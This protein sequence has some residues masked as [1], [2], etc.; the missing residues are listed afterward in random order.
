M[1]TRNGSWVWGF[2]LLDSLFPTKCSDRITTKWKTPFSY[3]HVRQTVLSLSMIWFTRRQYLTPILRNRGRMWAMRT[4]TLYGLKQS[5][6]ERFKLLSSCQES[7]RLV[8]TRITAFPALDRPRKIGGWSRQ[9]RTVRW[10]ARSSVD[11]RSRSVNRFIP[12]WKT[13]SHESFNEIIQSGQASSSPFNAFRKTA[14]EVVIWHMR[15][16]TRENCKTLA[17][18]KRISAEHEKTW[19]QNVSDRGTI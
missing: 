4:S 11:S 17:Y 5:P 10:M 19:L 16:E 13:K 15:R 7:K 8:C 3:Q 12:R 6:Q 1:T 18:S 14:S 9:V 2:L